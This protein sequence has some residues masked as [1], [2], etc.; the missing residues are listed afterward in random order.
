MGEL[1]AGLYAKP[2][3]RERRDVTSLPLV[4]SW[5]RTSKSCGLEPM[6]T[7][8]GPDDNVVHLSCWEMD[9]ETEG[10]AS[11][12]SSKWGPSFWAPCQWVVSIEMMPSAAAS[13]SLKSREMDISVW[14]YLLRRN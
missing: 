2:T 7:E 1:G 6:V 13:T 14:E 4:V 11:G 8:S 12:K 9:G 5:N 3:L 10:L